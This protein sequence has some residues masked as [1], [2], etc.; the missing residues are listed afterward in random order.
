MIRVLAVVAV[1]GWP[2]AL[3]RWFG[4]DK[5]KHFLMSAMVQSTVYSS[6]RAVGAT[7]Q[8]SQLVGGGAVAGIGLLKEVRD[9]RAHKPFSIEDLVWDV[10]GGIAAAALLNGTSK[11]TR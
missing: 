7:N 4:A 10:S 1:L 9:R 6:A 2:A 11:G 8:A 3:G 5:V